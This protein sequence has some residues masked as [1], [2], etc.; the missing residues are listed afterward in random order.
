[1]SLSTLITDFL[2]YLEL[3]QHASRLTIRNYSHYLKRFLEFACLEAKLR[4]GDIEPENINLSLAEQYRLYLSCWTDPKTKKRLKLVTQNYFLIA[5][6][7]Y[8][9]YLAK[10][11]IMTLSAEEIRLQNTP[12]PPAKILDGDKLRD[13]L[14]AP[15]SSQRGL[16]D[17]AIM[18]TLSAGGLR[19]SEL[20][21]LDRDTTFPQGMEADGILARYLQSRHDSF[22]PLFI[23][24]QGKADPSDNGESMRLTPRGIQR[25]VEKY[26]K[27]LGFSVKAT[28]Q[29]LRHCFRSK[30]G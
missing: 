28:P 12:R 11:G 13:L 1:M 8:L 23:R 9:R 15:D 14:E 4:A 19:V 17:Q 5:L 10:K 21:K 7:A 18:Q 26:V 29:T 2:E 25:V 22:K 3:E 30:H 16:R 27:R 6:R 24:F 20:A